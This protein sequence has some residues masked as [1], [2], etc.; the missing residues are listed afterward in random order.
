MENKKK[1]VFLRIFNLFDLAL[2]AIALVVLAVILL[3]RDNSSGQLTGQVQRTVSVRYTVELSEIENGAAAN[4]K[5][6]APVVD[7]IKK[8]SIGTVESVQIS[9]TRASV[10]DEGSD[11]VRYAQVPGQETATVVITAKA[12]ETDADIIIDGGYLVK[13]GL[14]ASVRIPGLRATGFIVDVERSDAQ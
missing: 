8:Y 10:P 7:A 11:I 9:P 4:I 14:P 3:T 13:V 2:I 5:A 12:V 1:R 6:G